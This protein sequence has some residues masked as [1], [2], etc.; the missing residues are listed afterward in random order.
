RRASCDS[1]RVSS[2]TRS[3]DTL[4]VGAGFAGIGAAIR[5]EREGFTDFAILEKAGE[6]GGTW[7]DNTYPGAACD[8]QSHLYCFSFEP[9]PDWRKSFACSAE[10]QAYLLGVVARHGVRPRIRFGCEVLEAAWDAGAGRWRLKTS[11]G[12][13]DARVLIAGVGPLSE[14]RIAALPGLSSF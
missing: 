8:V 1:R 4:I 14:P 12:D 6:I 13:Y 7:R 3:F 9:N 5:L 2:D 11:Q 10:I